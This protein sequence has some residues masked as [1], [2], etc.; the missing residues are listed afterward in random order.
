MKC[1]KCGEEMKEAIADKRFYVCHKC[2]KLIPKR[3]HETVKGK[4]TQAVATKDE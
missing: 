2:K 3:G 4:E 1:P